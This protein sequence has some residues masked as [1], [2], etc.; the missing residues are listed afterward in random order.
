MR[1]EKKSNQTEGK[2]NGSGC[3]SSRDSVLSLRTRLA[4]RGGRQK[5]RCCNPG[6]ERGSGTA[7]CCVPPGSERS[8]RSGDRPWSGTAAGKGPAAARAGQ[9]GRE[10]VC[11]AKPLCLSHWSPGRGGGKKKKKRKKKKKQNNPDITWQLLS[12]N[13]LRASS[14]PCSLPFLPKRTNARTDG[15]GWTDG[16]TD[17]RSRP[18]GGCGVPAP[19]RPSEGASQRGTEGR[20]HKYRHK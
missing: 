10:G 2:K 9:R 7:R 14:A 18:G 8:V 15:P 3:K 4:E 17:G 11:K 13:P 19:P 5:G 16:R 1:K 20:G 12:P 6:A